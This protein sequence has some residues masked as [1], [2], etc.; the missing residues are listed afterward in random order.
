M[1]GRF[2]YAGLT[3]NKDVKYDRRRDWPFDKCLSYNMMAAYNLHNSKL[4][5]YIRS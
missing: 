3:R 2:G 1:N 5:S 4:L